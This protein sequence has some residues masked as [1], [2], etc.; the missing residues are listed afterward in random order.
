MI[1]ICDVCASHNI[2]TILLE[3]YN[4]LRRYIECRSSYNER[5]SSATKRFPDFWSLYRECRYI[6]CR[7]NDSLLYYYYCV[8]AHVQSM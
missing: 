7:Y 1:S 6:E 2:V 8:G 5:V 4:I 3:P